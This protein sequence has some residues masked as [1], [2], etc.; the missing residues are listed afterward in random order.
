MRK[1][2]IGRKG[3][4]KKNVVD[5]CRNMSELDKPCSK[6]EYDSVCDVFVLR[7]ARTPITITDDDK[8][9]SNEVLG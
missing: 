5:H 7:T 9:Y 4:T 3:I 6:C 1:G 8:D 2:T